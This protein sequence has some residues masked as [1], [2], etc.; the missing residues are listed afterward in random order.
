MNSEPNDDNFDVHE[1]DTEKPPP[2]Y[3]KEKKDKDGKRTE[4]WKKY[5]PHTGEELDKEDRK[6]LREA[7]DRKDK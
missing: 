1:D 7:I 6:N 5:D 2:G 4:S 3:S